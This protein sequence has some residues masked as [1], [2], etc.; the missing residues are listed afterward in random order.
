MWIIWSCSSLLKD[1]HF[2]EPVVSDT[3]SVAR[4]K[5]S[6]RMGCWLWLRHL[7][8]FLI[9]FP[10]LVTT[11]LLQTKLYR[12][13]GFGLCCC[14]LNWWHRTA[15]SSSVTNS[16]AASKSAWQGSYPSR[17]LSAWFPLQFFS[18]ICFLFFFYFFF[19]IFS[20]TLHKQWAEVREWLPRIDPIYQ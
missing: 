18:T 6:W 20:S 7:M 11:S 19:F 10:S 4:S 9:L 5:K 17:F 2:V 14:R 3:K 8:L 16:T 13:N 12:F 1:H 15:R